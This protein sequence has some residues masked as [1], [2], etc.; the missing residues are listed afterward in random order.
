MPP[1]PADSGSSSLSGGT[2]GG[3]VGGVI[4]GLALLALIAGI[5]IYRRKKHDRPVEQDDSVRY[6]DHRQ[7]VK[8]A[9]EIGGEG[10]STAAPDTHQS[11]RYLEPD[12]PNEPI[13]AR[14]G[15]NY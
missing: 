7:S 5:C 4:G 10:T 8:P 1:T 3:I 15:G 13:G 6:F 12:Y 2:I 11:L 9:F 14:T